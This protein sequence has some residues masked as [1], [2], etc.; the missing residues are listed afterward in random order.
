MEVQFRLL[1]R[2][3]GFLLMLMAPLQL[4][5]SV[6]MSGYQAD[7]GDSS[8]ITIYGNELN[9]TTSLSIV[10]LNNGQF[11]NNIPFVLLGNTSMTV[12]FN[13]PAGVSF[14]NSAVFLE[15]ESQGIFGIQ[16]SYSFSRIV[17]GYDG[18]NTIG[19]SNAIKIN[20]GAG[21]S[22]TIMGGSNFFFLD[23]FARFTGN[24]IG[25]GNIIFLRQGARFQATSIGGGN[26]VFMEFG[27]HYQATSM[28]D[29]NVF[30]ESGATVQKTSGTFSIKYLS[31]IVFTSLAQ[32]PEP[33][34]VSLLA[35]GLGA[36]AM[37]RRRRL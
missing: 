9:A 22:A 5:G 33:S 11:I 27:S 29:S 8:V 4:V 24:Q 13:L 7:I 36:L 19:G 21:F 16:D 3:Y 12:H 37:M 34:A 35:V 17:S 20:P 23:S 32:I 2:T 18:V 1:Y 25:G 28:G 15:A 30:L 14:N 26:T 6:S 31:D 10:D